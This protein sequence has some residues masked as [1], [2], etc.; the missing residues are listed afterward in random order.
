MTDY[1]T[2]DMGP[3]YAETDLS[4]FPAEPF[5]TFSNILFLL[6]AIYWIR[7]ISG[8]KEPFKSFLKL[9]MPILLVGFVGGTVFHATRSHFGWLLMDVLPIFVLGL[10][11]S[12]YH[13]KLLKVS[14]WKVG[15]FFVLFLC[16][17]SWVLWKFFSRSPNS[18]TISYLLLALVIL[19]PILFDQ[20]KNS[21]K[22]GR[23]LMA[24]IGLVSVALI[25]RALDSSALVQASSFLP[26]THWLWHAF[27][28]ATCHF[29]LCFMSLRARDL[30]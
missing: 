10:L 6:V 24:S 26:G 25:C 9:S 30:S 8:Q 3:W 4:R 7:K 23:W 12:I 11:T 16:L 29:L 27:G 19:F 28:A 13:W 21:W 1:Q 14:L 5:N 17:P 15:V 18:P 22:Q 2:P 20:W